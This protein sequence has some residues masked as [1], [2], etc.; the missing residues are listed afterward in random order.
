[1][2]DWDLCFDSAIIFAL[3]DEILCGLFKKDSTTQKI[4]S[5]NRSVF[6]DAIS[7]HP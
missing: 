7:S 5:W 3:R 4:F 1:M 6:K 2:S